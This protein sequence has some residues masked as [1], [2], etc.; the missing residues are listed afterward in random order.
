MENATAKVDEP[1]HQ[2][3]YKSIVVLEQ[4]VEDLV[5]FVNKLKG[6][7]R[8]KRGEDGSK[9]LPDLSIVDVLNNSGDAINACSKRIS[10]CIEEMGAVLY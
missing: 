6:E 7:P 4:T 3:I 10:E 9:G 5:N 8:D 1:K 2:N